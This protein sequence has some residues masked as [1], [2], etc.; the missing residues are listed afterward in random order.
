M[1]SIF[2]YLKSTHLKK[3]ILFFQKV[4]FTPTIEKNMTIF[5]AEIKRECLFFIHLLYQ[6]Y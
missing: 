1:L 5:L 6:E 4:F 2:W 3:N